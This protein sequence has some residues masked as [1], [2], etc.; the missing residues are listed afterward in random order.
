MR[1]ILMS[2]IWRI[3]NENLL[4]KLLAKIAKYFGLTPLNANPTKWS[5]TQTIRQQQPTN[6]L[7]AF[8]HFV[9]LALKG[10]I[11]LQSL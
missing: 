8:D 3:L 4:T 11:R 5:D 7:S 1:H 9:G 2:K 10:L 6:C